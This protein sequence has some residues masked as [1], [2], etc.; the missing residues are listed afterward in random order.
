[1]GQSIGNSAVQAI[2]FR[3]AHLH[4]DIVRADRW[5]CDE[6]QFDQIPLQNRRAAYRSI[7]DPPSHGDISRAVIRRRSVTTMRDAK[8][9]D[10]VEIAFN[11]SRQQEDQ[12]KRV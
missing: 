7:D 6:I 10:G 9:R 2:E 3:P 12:R 8:A 4:R 5:I 11:E 1:V